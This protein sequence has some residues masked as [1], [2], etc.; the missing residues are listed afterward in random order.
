[1]FGLVG[2][3]DDV[4]RLENDGKHAFTNRDRFMGSSTDPPE[5]GELWHLAQPCRLYL[6]N[7]FFHACKFKQI[8]TWNGMVFLPRIAKKDWFMLY[9]KEAPN[10]YIAPCFFIKSS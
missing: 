6:F 1:M 5:V 3:D 7:D 8:A 2:L 10:I 4:L 9:A